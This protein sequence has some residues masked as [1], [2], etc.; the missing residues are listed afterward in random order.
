M[1]QRRLHQILFASLSLVLLTGCDAPTNPSQPVDARGALVLASAGAAT[2]SMCA[3]QAVPAGYTVVSTSNNAACPGYAAG[4]V[5]VLTIRPVATGL[6]ICTAWPVGSG[7]T[8]QSVPSGYV[9]VRS[10]RKTSCPYYTATGDPNALQ[11]AV[12]DSATAICMR[13]PAPGGAMSQGVPAGFVV[14]GNL[15]TPSCA[16]YN[17]AG[18]P[19]GL[20]IRK[21]A[22]PMAI[23]S[24]WPVPGGYARQ[25]VPA[26]YVVVGATRTASCGYYSPTGDENSLRIAMP[27]GPTSVCL[28]WP[29]AGTSVVQQPPLGYVVVG[30]ARSVSCP[31]YSVSG[32][33]N[34]LTIRPPVSGTTFCM[35]WAVPTGTAWQSLPA[36]FVVSGSARST[37]CPYYSTSGEPNALTIRSTPSA[38][39]ICLRW[40]SAAGYT[41]QNVPAGFVA[42]GA[43]RSSS[44]PYYSATGDPNSLSIAV[45]AAGVTMCLRWPVPGSYVNQAVPAG[46]IVTASPRATGCAYYSATGD[47]N[48]LTIRPP[49]SPASICLRWPVP[50]GYTRQN[51]PA[52][53]A[54][55]GATHTAGCA[56]YTPTGNP[57]TLSMRALTTGLTICMWWPI[58]G[59]NVTQQIPA[60]YVYTHTVRAAACPYYNQYGAPNAWVIARV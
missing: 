27:S 17:A 39:T 43:A 40:P 11:I 10:A 60:G 47:P 14:V 56:Y 23:C 32:E 13:W 35:R 7:Y 55:V 24:R 36:G 22:G 33:P 1:S 34:V 26:G 42:T 49:V 5:N 16:Y 3:G 54:V 44:C 41:R 8:R 30:T 48:A 57:N 20:S 19:N 37:V 9:N 6:T 51:A 46:F 2:I 45:P 12:A 59:G 38:S 25:E 21:P 15:R 31:F 50:G 29:I 52:G 18:D 58:P 4:T 28:R 53:Y